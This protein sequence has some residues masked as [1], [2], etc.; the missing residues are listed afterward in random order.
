VI[1]DDESIIISSNRGVPLTL[2]DDKNAA[3]DAFRDIARR[4]AG[5]QVPLRDMSGAASGGV[6]RRLARRLGLSV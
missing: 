1:P 6:L 3:S 4:V 5:E 2:D